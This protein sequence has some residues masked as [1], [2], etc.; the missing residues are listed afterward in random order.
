VTAKPVTVVSDR[1]DLVALWIAPGTRWKRPRRPDGRPVGVVD[2]LRD[3]WLLA[4]AIWIG[5]GALIL[6]TPGAAHA[7]LGFWDESHESIRSWYL[8]LQAPLRRTPLGFDTLD[9]ILDVVISS[10]RASWSWK[11]EA[12][13]AEAEARRLISPEQARA[14]RDEGERALRMLLAGEL[15][16]AQEWEWWR[17]PTWPIPTLPQ[18]WETMFD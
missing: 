13:F 12:I 17:P 1:P 9:H 7:L 4:D 18:G 8:N 11:D 15:P 5:G 16:Y 2:V 14:I 6:H 3:D 10:D